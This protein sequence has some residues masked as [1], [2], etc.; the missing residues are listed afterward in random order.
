M[1]GAREASTGRGICKAHLR[2]PR[3]V[4]WCLGKRFGFGRAQERAVQGAQPCGPGTCQGAKRVCRAELATRHIA[5]MASSH[6]VPRATAPTARRYTRST[7]SESGK[8]TP[9]SYPLW[10]GFMEYWRRMRNYASR[11]RRQRGRMCRRMSAMIEGWFPLYAREQRGFA[12]IS[13][14]APRRFTPTNPTATNASA[15]AT[16][17]RSAT[18]DVGSPHG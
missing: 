12:A 17:T 10:S 7:S 11:S 14:L 16:V 9:R 8:S 2:G 15:T 4:R 13:D 5:K 1:P 18:S 3:T 6:R